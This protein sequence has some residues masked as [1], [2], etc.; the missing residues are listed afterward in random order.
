MEDDNGGTTKQQQ[1]IV[2]IEM[3][4]S[5]GTYEEGTYEDEQW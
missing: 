1:A 5:G 3:N 4:N 2:R